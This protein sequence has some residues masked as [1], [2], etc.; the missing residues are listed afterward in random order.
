VAPG[1]LRGGQRTTR[2]STIGTRSSRGATLKNCLNACAAL[3]CLLLYLHK[4]RAEAGTLVPAPSL[5]RAG[6]GHIA[7]LDVGDLDT[8]IRYKLEGAG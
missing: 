2:S 1:C 6:P 7:Y 8:G 4:D 5:L 3:F